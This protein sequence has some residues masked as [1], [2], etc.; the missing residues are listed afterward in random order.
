MRASASA[1]M[2][3][4]GKNPN[5]VFLQTINVLMFDAVAMYQHPFSYFFLRTCK[6]CCIFAA[7]RLML[8]I[9]GAGMAECNRGCCP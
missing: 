2:S 7:Q 1:V 3:L 6:N 5:N 4:Y 9:V 8:G